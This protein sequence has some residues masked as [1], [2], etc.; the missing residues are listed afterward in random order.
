MYKENAVEIIVLLQ[1]KL[2]GVRGTPIPPSLQILIT[3][4]FLACGTFHRETGDLCG[5]SESTV[6]NVLHNVCTAICELKEDCINAAAQAI[7]KVKFYEY[8][9]FP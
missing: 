9:N 5:V 3:L 1:P 8:G 4:R 2:S 6:C 7:Y